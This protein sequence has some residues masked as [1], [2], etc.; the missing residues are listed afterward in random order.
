LSNHSSLSGRGEQS[1]ESPDSGSYGRE[2]ELVGIH[3]ARLNPTDLGDIVKRL[4]FDGLAGGG[5]E[6][7]IQDRVFY[8]VVI[9]GVHFGTKERHLPNL[10]AHFFENLTPQ[11]DLGRFPDLDEP[12]GQRQL[13]PFRVL[14]AANEEGRAIGS[15]QDDPGGNG[16]VEMIQK[17]AGGTVD[18]IGV[19][20]RMMRSPAG[21]RI[22]TGGF[23]Q[24]LAASRAMSEVLDRQFHQ[25]S[26][27]SPGCG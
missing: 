18:D 12:P 20:R 25:G 27:R 2:R 11:T 13:A 5:G 16:G 6:E 24:R 4:G 26:K 21:E 10:Q 7:Q 9:V 19:K 17:I 22:R 1:S 14:G 8:R 15:R 23:R 3:Q